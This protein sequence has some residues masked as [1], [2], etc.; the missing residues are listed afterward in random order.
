MLE[1]YY[2]WDNVPSSLSTFRERNRQED[3]RNLFCF[4][5]FSENDG[6]FV[7]RHSYDHHGLCQRLLTSLQELVRLG[8]DRTILEFVMGK[9]DLIICITN[10]GAFYWD[11]IPKDSHLYRTLQTNWI[12]GKRLECAAMSFFDSRQF[13]LRSGDGRSHFL[14]STEYLPILNEYCDDENADRTDQHLQLMT[15]IIIGNDGPREIARRG[16]GDISLM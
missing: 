11:N 15:G 14:V 7:Q 5:L 10:T 4:V 1:L 6:W 13:F 2:N 3:S 8:L 16:S 12:Q 9:D